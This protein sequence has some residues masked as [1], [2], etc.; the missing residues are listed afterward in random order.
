MVSLTILVYSYFL[1]NPF[2]SLLSFLADSSCWYSTIALLSFQWFDLY[3][4]LFSVLE[5]VQCQ[6]ISLELHCS[7]E[8]GRVLQ[9]ARSLI[10][11][12]EISFHY[13]YVQT[14]NSVACFKRL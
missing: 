3:C 7:E 2:G 9:Q 14:T 5:V 13:F 4:I 12:K 1:D 10:Q 6:R 8:S 11:E